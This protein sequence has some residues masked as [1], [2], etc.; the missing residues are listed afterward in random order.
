MSE[1]KDVSSFCQ[2]DKERI[3]NCFESRFGK[4][5]LVVHRHIHYP[6]DMWLASCYPN[7]FSQLE[8]ASKDIEGAK[9][10]AKA[11]LQAIL[12]KAVAELAKVSV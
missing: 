3:P 2:T 8:L 5:R 12:E 11:M 10:Q 7:V 1:W 6:K 9:C 4:F